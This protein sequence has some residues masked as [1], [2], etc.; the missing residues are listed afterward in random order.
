MPSIL[1]AGTAH[2]P[3]T[4]H[5]A[6]V[7]PFVK[8]MFSD[9]FSDIDRL[10]GLFENTG[11]D[12]RQFC[13]PMEWFK[14]NPGFKEKNSI[15]IENAV[16][17]GKEALI[18]CMEKCQVDIA[19][20]S[21]LFFI[22]TTGMATPSIDVRILNELGASTHTKRTPIWGLGCAGGAVGISRALDYVKSYPTEVVAVVAVELC[23]LTFQPNDLTKSNLVA[24][25][26]FADGAAAVLI[27]GDQAEIKVKAPIQAIKSMSTYWPDSLDVMGWDFSSSGFHVIF[28]RDI[29]T[30]VKTRVADE[31]HSFLK[32]EQIEQIDH[33][34]IHPGGK[35]V[36]E[37]FQKA[38]DIPEE[39]L[40]I[41]RQ[42]LKENGNMSSCTVLYV[43]NEFI[44]QKQMNPGEKG[45]ISALGPGF[46]AEMILV[47]G[48]H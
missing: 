39:K 36:L 46:S 3:Y 2:L 29:P 45:L 7:K 30:I 5:Q 4:F 13:V 23:G 25:S 32:A 19:D 28:S 27:A 47:E 42:V 38:L 16:L 48:T 8:D 12:T 44:K 37:A 20:I 6:D 11:I 1:G 26:L 15:Y 33:Y 43:L 40:G 24:T 21:H 41:T 22:S 10:I 35:K 14:N 31:V 17:Y 18:H 9:I 34:I